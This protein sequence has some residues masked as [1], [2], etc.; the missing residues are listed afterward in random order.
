MRAGSLAA[1]VL[2]FL[3]AGVTAQYYGPQRA[4]FAM[5]ILFV[6]L[7]M[8]PPV[9]FALAGVG[10]ARSDLRT[11]FPAAAVSTAGV[12]Y[13][14]LPLAALL[15]IRGAPLGTFWLLYLLVVVWAGDVCAYY[16]GK[17]F[18]R[19]LMAPRISPKKTWEGAAAS[20]VGSMLFAVLL[21]ITL[22]HWP[23]VGQDARLVLRYAPPLWLAA[24]LAIPLNLAAQVG[25]LVESMLKRGAEVKDSGSLLP[26]HGGVLDRIDALLFAAPLLWYLLAFAASIR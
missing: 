9:F 5:A 25:D 23:G 14:G 11:A 3:A 4:D 8:V 22:P 6:S 18:G 24:F 26:G 13:I 15:A 21:T 7:L 2:L 10:L 1:V 16:V 20:V 19:L 12:I 17:S